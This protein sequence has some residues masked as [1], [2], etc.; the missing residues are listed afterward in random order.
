[1]TELDGKNNCQTAT[2]GKQRQL[3]SQQPQQ[4]T[5]SLYYPSPYAT[6]QIDDRA[7]VVH[8]LQSQNCLEGRQTADDGQYATVKRTPRLPKSDR[9]IYT[10]PTKGRRSARKHG[11]L[12]TRKSILAATFPSPNLYFIG[13]SSM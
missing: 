8:F 1:M 6:T 9:H 3:Q 13:K 12:M 4:Q 7:K 10:Y 5:T 2:L 11:T